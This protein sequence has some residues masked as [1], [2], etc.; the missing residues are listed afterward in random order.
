MANRLSKE[1]ARAIAVEYYTNGFQK[2][3]ALLSVGYSKTYANNVG[4]KI[5][6]NERMVEAMQRLSAVAVVRTGYSIEQ[7]QN[8]YELARIQAMALKQPAAA[9]SAITGKARLHALDRDDGIKE[10]TKSD[11]TPEQQEVIDMFSKRLLIKDLN[12][13][14]A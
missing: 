10:D 9:V 11:Y 7:S 13:A 2:V 12:K 3:A 1:R 14:T 5:F 6:D 8:E 4:L